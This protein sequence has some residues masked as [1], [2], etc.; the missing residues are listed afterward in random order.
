MYMSSDSCVV[1]AA[2]RE[3]PEWRNPVRKVGG[4]PNGRFG[5]LAMSVMGTFASLDR[6]LGARVAVY[7]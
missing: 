2:V 4:L 6:T 7:C 5:G 1:E 3:R